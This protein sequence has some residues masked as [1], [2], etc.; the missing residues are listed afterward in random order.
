MAFKRSNLPHGE[1]LPNSI[2]Y[3]SASETSE[4]QKCHLNKSPMS[5]PN[6]DRVSR[7]GVSYTYS[8]IYKIAYFNIES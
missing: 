7:L 4:I 2:C 5:A 1:S 3:Y 8:L 6:N